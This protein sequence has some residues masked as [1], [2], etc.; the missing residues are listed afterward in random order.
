MNYLLVSHSSFCNKSRIL[1]WDVEDSA[2]SSS[3]STIFDFSFN[4]GM[5]E[6]SISTFLFF[7]E[8]LIGRPIAKDY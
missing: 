7:G 6:I 8:D 3:I 1:L 2:N 4:R 5:G